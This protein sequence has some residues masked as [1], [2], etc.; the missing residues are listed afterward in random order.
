MET[1]GASLICHLSGLQSQ[2]DVSGSILTVDGV[3]VWAKATQGQQPL[4]E[5]VTRGTMFFPPPS[6][7]HPGITKSQASVKNLAPWCHS[8]P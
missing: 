1:Q 2:L 8:D 4:G 7:G 6:L 3:T 5:V